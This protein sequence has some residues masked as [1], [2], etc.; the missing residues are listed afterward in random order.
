MRPAPM[1]RR[2]WFG[3]DDG[4]VRIDIRALIERAVRQP[5]RTALR[6]VRPDPAPPAPGPTEPRDP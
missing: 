4:T 1:T 2:P 6:L 3:D 5:L